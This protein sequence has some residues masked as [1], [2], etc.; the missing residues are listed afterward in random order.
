MT[1]P[2]ANSTAA[3]RRPKGT[4]MLLV[5]AEAVRTEL[6]NQLKAMDIPVVSVGSVAQAVAKLDETVRVLLID[7]SF[8]AESD[9]VLAKAKAADVRV[10]AAGTGLQGVDVL[11]L[12]ETG[13]IGYIPMPQPPELI[14]G[15]LADQIIRDDSSRVSF[16]QVSMAKSELEAVFDT[17]PSP[18]FIVGPDMKM[19]RANKAT[20]QL[21]GRRS[22]KELIGLPCWEALGCSA[23]DGCAIKAAMEVDGIRTLHDIQTTEWTH[24]ILG[25]TY[26]PRILSTGTSTGDE[27]TL[28]GGVLIM[29]E[30]VT[31]FRR[32]ESASSREQ[33]LNAVGLLAATL[34]HEIN[35][36]LGAI[37]GRAQLAMIGLER[38]PLDVTA[39]K[40]DLEEV[41]LNVNRVSQI[42]DKLHQVTDIV[43][44]P[45]LGEMEILDLEKSSSHEQEK[46]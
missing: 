6:A 40:K 19:R 17:F 4:V 32:Y 34:S 7:A 46:E 38:A 14:A 42:L 13:A 43:T 16:K 36:P 2:M 29:I 39:L 26:R 22:Y 33:K 31:A 27:G 44:K 1:D 45:Y 12:M 9:A 20:L 11:N 5:E 10:L 37:M 41:V 23:Q 35:Q 25:R 30:D 15:Q 24:P 8:A 18:M 21:S 3:L 28:G